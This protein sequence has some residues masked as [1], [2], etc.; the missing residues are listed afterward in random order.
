[1]S[2]VYVYSTLSNDQAYTNYAPARGGA[3]NLAIQQH[4]V[5]IAGKANITDKRFVTPQGVVTKV[6]A[7]DFAALQ[8]NSVF[9]LHVENG[10]ITY[11]EKK[12]DADLVASDM[13]G[14]DQSA[15]DT[16]ESML[17]SGTDEEDLPVENRKSKK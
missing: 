6:S 5:V 10:F 14:R 13:T 11:S 16:P 1:M 9:K 8:Q 17:A 2:E 15:P 12:K 7:E 4:Q 3:N